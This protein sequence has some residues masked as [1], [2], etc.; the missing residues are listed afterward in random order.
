MA[1]RVTFI[2]TSVLCE[3]LNVPGMCSQHED[4]RTEF[5]LRGDDGERFVIPI[6]AVIETG[7]HIAQAAGNR[8]AT[9][10]RF[11]RFLTAAGLGDAPFSVHRPS[12]DD[13]FLVD[14]CE[15]NATGQPFIDLANADASYSSGINFV[16]D[17]LS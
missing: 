9:A 1:A 2:D 8:R 6:T 4:I 16:R 13:E 5:E 14:L 15:G 12:W 11:V 7:N 17:S 3:L 10:E